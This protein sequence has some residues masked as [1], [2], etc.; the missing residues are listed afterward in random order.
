[1]LHFSPDS[2]GDYGDDKAAA[3]R[4]NRDAAERRA[5]SLLVE[6][7]GTIDD[8]VNDPLVPL[9]TPLPIERRFSPC[10]SRS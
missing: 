7:N 9:T 3:V 1:M 4:L 8:V 6:Y 5:Q 10:F 2:H